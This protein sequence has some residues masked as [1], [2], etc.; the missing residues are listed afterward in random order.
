MH[1]KFHATG[2]AGATVLIMTERQVRPKCA[3]P[4][5]D[6]VHVFLRVQWDDDGFGEQKSGNHEWG[7]RARDLV[8]PSTRASWIIYRLIPGKRRQHL[9][10]ASSNM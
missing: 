5:H 1:G 8:S 6:R 3:I 9:P 2:F 10:P 4:I 7:K